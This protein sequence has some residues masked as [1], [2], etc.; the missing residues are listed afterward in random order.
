[1]TTAKSFRDALRSDRF[2]VTGELNP[3][4]GVAL[5]SLLAKAEQLR[6]TVDALNLTDSHA[7]RMAMAPL[8][9]AHQLVD[10]GIEPILQITSRD[11]NRIAIQGEL[12]AAHSLGVH[13]VVFMAGDPP[14]TGDHADAKAV[15]DV[16]ST[17]L[18]GAAR[19][20]ERGTDLAGNALEGRPWFCLGAVVNPGARN[21]DEELQRMRTKLE[22][23]AEFL[24]TQAVY[25]V[26]GFERFVR[27]V[28]PLSPRLI[29]GIILLKSADMG[30]YMNENI[31]GIHVPEALIREMEGAADRA[32]AAVRIAARTVRDVRPL[33]SGVHV[34]AIGWES[35][36]AEVLEAAGI[37]R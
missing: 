12:L 24:Q 17:T 32:Q 36:I 2:V 10:R 19:A 7:S 15:F 26:A 8:A 27:R 23:G 21:L 30:R 4:K 34:M 20:M 5:D 28:E 37:E 18:L 31:P 3:P 29:A 11:R 14:A 6:G 16:D 13:N 35:R 22:A 1:L 25:D 9:V 33:C